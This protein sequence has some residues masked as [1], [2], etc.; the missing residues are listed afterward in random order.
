LLQI[1]AGNRC[2]VD[3]RVQTRDRDRSKLDV[4]QLDSIPVAEVGNPVAVV[5]AK[6]T[7]L[8]GHAG[9]ALEPSAV[10][11]DVGGVDLQ[12]DVLALANKRAGRSTELTL[13][14]SLGCTKAKDRT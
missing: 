8:G 14:V 6:A 1:V 10:R 7:E 5:G 13:G 3:P 2:L 9:Q 4:A 11:L 12:H